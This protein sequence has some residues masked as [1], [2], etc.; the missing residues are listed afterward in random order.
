MCN[1][2]RL[3]A[4]AHCTM[5]N[6]SSYLLLFCFFSLSFFFFFCV[7]Y[8]LRTTLRRVKLFAY[9][10]RCRRSL[11][12]EYNAHSAQIRTL[13]Q[14]YCAIG[15]DRIVFSLQM[16]W[17]GFSLFFAPLFLLVLLLW[18]KRKETRY[19]TL[20]TTECGYE[21]EGI[22]GKGAYVKWIKIVFIL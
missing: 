18:C 11:Q 12:I 20:C 4:T 14:Q 19:S 17:W 5:H 16:T 3:L 8:G 10:Q 13:R 2:N 1:G 15:L 22:D 7:R 21:S 6:G 9:N